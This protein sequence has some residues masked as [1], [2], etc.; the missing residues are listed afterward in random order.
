MLRIPGLWLFLIN[1]IFTFN[2]PKD[3]HDQKVFSQVQHDLLERERSGRSRGSPT[4]KKMM[5]K[6]LSST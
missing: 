5:D 4:L 1:T 6:S 3:H 2:S